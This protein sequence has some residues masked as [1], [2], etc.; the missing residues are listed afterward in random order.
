MQDRNDDAII[1]AVIA[2]LG[3][4]RRGQWMRA[5]IQDS[6]NRIRSPGLVY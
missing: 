3:F 6:L 1:D 4:A 5:T 2:E